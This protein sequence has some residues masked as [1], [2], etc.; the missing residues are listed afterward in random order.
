VNA[1][2][3]AAIVDVVVEGVVVVVVDEDVVEPVGVVVVVEDVVVV[4]LVDAVHEATAIAN[5][6]NGIMSFLCNPV[7]LRIMIVC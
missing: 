6:A 3:V 2:P 1:S 7:P 4:P 5:A